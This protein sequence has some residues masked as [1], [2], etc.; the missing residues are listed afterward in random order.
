MITLKQAVIEEL[1]NSGFFPDQALEVFERLVTDP[2]QKSMEGR[3]DDDYTDY[4]KPIFSI[5]LVAV[6]SIALKYIEEKIPDAWFRPMFDDNL[7][8]TLG[9]K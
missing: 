7:A 6:K 8:K 1:T 5:L 3:W 9:I 4:P 2:A